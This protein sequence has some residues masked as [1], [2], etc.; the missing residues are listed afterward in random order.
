M[1]VSPNNWTLIA[2]TIF[3]TAVALIGFV[4]AGYPLLMFLFSRLYGKSVRRAPI[5]PRV[6]LIIAAR[7]EEAAIGEKLENALS[8]DYPKEKFEIIVASDA[9]TDRTDEIVRSFAGRGVILHRQEKRHGK[10]RAQHRAA[11]VSTGQIL[12]FSDATTI[13]EPDAVEKIVR[14]FADPN[15]GCVA[16]QLVYLDDKS[17]AVS[18]GCKSYWNYEKRLK[19]WESSFNSLIGVS[20][21]LYAVRR[22][23]YAKFAKDMIDDFVIAIE[24]HIQG[25]RTI[26]EPLAISKED[27][28][29][30]TKDEMRMRIR[31]IEQTIRALSTYREVLN[32]QKHGQFAFQL[33]CHKVLRY[34]VPVFLLVAF[35]ANYFAWEGAN[36][37]MFTFIGQIIVYLGALGGYIRDRL[38]KNLGPMAIPYYFIL[39][40][41]APVLAFIKFMRGESHVVWEPVRESEQNTIKTQAETF[42]EVG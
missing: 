7:N 42:S 25:L 6:S 23:C 5:F 41:I 35:I 27:A 11:G 24:I 22:S 33:L 29:R 20:G 28:N 19:Q 37:F 40:N 16:G 34:L 12:I 13:Y 32:L 1:P 36:F 15:V 8:L 39:V 10:T 30:R 9:S 38:G 26:Y 18:S 14:N 3:L 2:Q 4:Y 31:V 17:S 21:C